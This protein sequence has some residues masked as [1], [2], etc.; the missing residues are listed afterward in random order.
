[1]IG[2]GERLEAATAYA[3]SLPPAMAADARAYI[4]YW[5]NGGP[6]PATRYPMMRARLAAM[7]RGA[8]MKAKGW[9]G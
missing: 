7:L 6:E 8:D 9:Y 4:R 1:M 5:R 2:L 3:D